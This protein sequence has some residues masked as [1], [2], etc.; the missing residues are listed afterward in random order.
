LEGKYE[1]YAYALFESLQSP[2]SV[3]LYLQAAKAMAILGNDLAWS[4]RCEVVLG[5]SPLDFGSQSEWKAY[6]S[7]MRALFSSAG[8][9]AVLR[10]VAATF[11]S[12]TA[13]SKNEWLIL[14]FPPSQWHLLVSDGLVN[15]EFIDKFRGS[16][17]EKIGNLVKG[18][19]EIA[20]LVEHTLQPDLSVSI[21]FLKVIRIAV[22][23]HNKGTLFDSSLA[24]DLLGLA[25]LDQ[26]HVDELHRLIKSVQNH[27]VFP[28]SWAKAVVEVA[29]SSDGVDLKLIS[30]FWES[31]TSNRDIKLWLRM[32]PTMEPYRYYKIISDL[33][34]VKSVAALELISFIAMS[35]REPIAEVSKDLNRRAASGLCSN[36]LSDSRIGTHVHCLLCSKPTIEEAKL[37]GA[38]D[39]F[40]RVRSAARHFDSQVV[41]RLRSMPQFLSREDY[42]ALKIELMRL[43]S[44]K[45]EYPPEVSAA[46]IDALIQI[47]ISV[48]APISESE[49]QSEPQK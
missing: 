4:L 40:K 49:W 35:D 26:A 42:P 14:M 22:E 28:A 11:A 15:A 32:I 6:K 18:Q 48:C 13:S 21:L 34:E 19:V 38:C 44:R 17:W 45:D 16:R 30:E 27:A 33:L 41:E 5:P 39:V 12:A 8:E 31:V 20:G 7:E 29:L 43:L 36:G 1:A 9:I 3:D 25:R 47:D 24:G 23:L 37:Y 46:A 10:N 2:D